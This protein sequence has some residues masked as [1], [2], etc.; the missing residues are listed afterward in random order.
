MKVLNVTNSYQIYSSRQVFSARRVSNPK[1]QF[2]AKQSLYNNIDAFMKHKIDKKAY[3]NS[4][5]EIIRQTDNFDDFTADEKKYIY[6]IITAIDDLGGADKIP[7]S[8]ITK[9]MKDLLETKDAV[10][11]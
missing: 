1:V 9:L 5:D 7:S 6:K 11:S 8:Y 3:L 4:L 10:G 2:D